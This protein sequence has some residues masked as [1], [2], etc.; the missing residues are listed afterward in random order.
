MKICHCTSVHARY[1][2]RIFLKQC[3][4]LAVAG[5]QVFL[6]VADGLGN[7]ERD[8]V[9]ILDAG[10]R[11]TSRR[12]RMR[13][14][15]RAVRELAAGLQADAYH[16]HDPEL[17]PAGLWLRRKV[18]NTRVIYDAH[19]DLPQQIMGKAWLPGFVRPFL[20]WYMGRYLRR[21]CLRFDAV[22]GATPHITT[23]Y[24]RFAQ[25]SINVNNYPILGELEVS[26]K[27][28][29]W[30]AKRQVCY[31]GGL[32]RIRGIQE[33]VRA[34]ANVQKDIQLVLAGEFISDGLQEDVQQDVG[35]LRTS[36][37]GFLNR[38]EIAGLLSQSLAGLVTLHGKQAYLD[39]LPVKMFEY[40]SAGIPVIASDFPLWR[41]IVEGSSC[42]LC[43]DPQ[44]P[45]AIA[46]AI[47]ILAGDPATARKMGKN[48]RRAVQE[49]Y[50][51][52]Q[53]EK[54]LLNLYAELTVV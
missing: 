42:G 12:R 23:W 6:V 54:K 50:N 31:V 3:R 38:K 2:T 33:I 37:V 5:H 20:S 8:G 36:H 16:L 29:D 47:D 52:G 32:T 48:G 13:I 22:I 49:H 24:S 35:W 30:N 11:E 15:V 26:L 45:A 7:E 1:D 17:I 34:M 9:Q 27:E 51:W 25:R 41:S 44:D 21:Y 19:E 4:S 28:V 43:V 46:A 14:T 40:M 10:M 18:K 53:E 39:S